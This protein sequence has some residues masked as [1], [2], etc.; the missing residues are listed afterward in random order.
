MKKLF[1][2]LMFISAFLWIALKI[3]CLSAQELTVPDYSYGEVF[4]K[5]GTVTP[6]GVANP[7]PYGG[8]ST[9][10]DERPYDVFLGYGY[11]WWSYPGVPISICNDLPV[12]NY[13]GY[14]GVWDMSGL[15][16]LGDLPIGYM[17][18]WG[19]VIVEPDSRQIWSLAGAMNKNNG[20]TEQHCIGFFCYSPSS[21][22]GFVQS[23]GY[24]R[25]IVKVQ[26]TGSL[27]NG[28]P[29][30]IKASL[31]SQGVFE[32]DGDFLSTGVLL[33]NKMSETPWYQWGI[34][35][36]YLHWG[37]VADIIGSSELMN[38][39]LGNLV[40]NLNN[41]DDTTATVAIG[42]TIVVEVA[43]TNE[44]K[45]DNPGV[46][47]MGESEGWA[48][49]RP[50]DLFNN[51][52][53][54]RTDSIRNLIKKYG[55]SLTY[56]LICLTPGAV[57][58]PLTPA[59][60]NTDEDKDGISDAR[61]KGPDGNNSSFDGNSDGIPDYEQANV[62]SFH[63]FDGADYVTLVV[64]DGTELSQLIVT[65]N[66]S[67]LDAPDS[68]NF[69]YGFFDFS[70]DGLEL[71]EAITVRLILHGGVSVN[72][73]YKYGI[74]PADSTQHWYEFM[75]DGQTGAVINGNKITL[76][77]VDGLRG[78][79]DITVNG[80]IK[81]PG[82]PSRPAD[83]TF[84]FSVDGNVQIDESTSVNS[85][86]IY[87]YQPVNEGDSIDHWDKLLSGSDSFIF[88]T[89]PEGSITLRFDPDTIDYPGYLNTY[90]GNTPVYADAEFFNLVKDTSGL[91]ITLVQTPP[92]P[93]GNSEISGIFVEE[94]KNKSGS[95]LTYGKYNGKGTPVSEISVFLIDQNGNIFDFDLTESTGEFLFENIP[96]GQYK[97][98]ADYV[99]FFMDDTND[100]LII[101][102]E[103]QKFTIAAVAENNVITIEV[104]NIT[105]IS[106]L[107]EN[108]GIYVYPNP[109]IDHIILQF[110]NNIPADD[111][112]LKINSMT[113]KVMR[114]KIIHL[115]D[116]SQEFSIRIDDL[117]SGIYIITLS[118]NN[119]I[120]NARFIKL[121]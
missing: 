88:D 110:N 38:N 120:Y 25:K 50:S 57:L 71:G 100:S 7:G 15:G 62:A 114:K 6:Q 99:G 53:Y 13:P 108:S 49:E 102:Q 31:T 77:F 64:P 28:D 87:V 81:E 85:G 14:H 10:K 29:V 104:E 12:F 45:L 106:S 36:E 23:H 59:G 27:Q 2:I 47:S 33:L 92:P 52:V 32:G 40:M 18:S 117:P 103:N 41:T 82:A 60:P 79:E 24:L 3:N 16:C 46:R 44:I 39:M 116:V 48:G 76:H 91:E 54:A 89:I 90:L 61:E 74:S 19:G 97:F 95:I 8:Y 9:G 101:S 20:P 1:L 42:D 30:D 21:I 96:V 83:T 11:R 86:R 119:Y 84:S 113:G 56:D 109:A 5:Y 118:G 115:H 107:V 66:P 4:G 55:N 58:E 69:P 94:N 111:Y 63:T 80:S 75:Y 112:I 68:T 34:S 17:G 105:S 26:S 22:W 43:F 70:I 121:E 51:K 93:N 65:D 72:N 67:P 73:Y 37:T 35:E 78:D 98:A